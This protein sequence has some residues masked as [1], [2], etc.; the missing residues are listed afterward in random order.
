MS[1]FSP[2]KSVDV[3]A[4]ELLKAENRAL[5]AE[6]EVERLREAA[7]PFASPGL[8]SREHGDGPPEDDVLDVRIKM[9]D[10]F[11][12]NIAL[13][14]MDADYL[15]ALPANARP[16]DEFIASCEALS[17]AGGGPSQ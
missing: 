9:A 14:R 6:T 3:L 15:R 1:G 11:R 4:A 17:A 2:S 5:A 12:L 16:S 7:L 13:G 8:T 10:W